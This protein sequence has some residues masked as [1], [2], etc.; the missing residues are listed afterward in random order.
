ML[1][2]S[3]SPQDGHVAFL[4][5][6]SLS[7]SLGSSFIIYLSQ[8]EILFSLFAVVYWLLSSS[9]EEMISSKT[10]DLREVEG[11]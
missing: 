11:V 5:R 6:S 3:E 9:T 4:I 1:Q 7:V 2:V 10:P 8:S